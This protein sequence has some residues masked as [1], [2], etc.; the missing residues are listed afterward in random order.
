MSDVD[1]ERLDMLAFDEDDIPLEA[2]SEQEGGG[3]G[4][5]KAFEDMTEQMEMSAPI[6]AQTKL[7]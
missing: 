4:A 6:N 5:G 7:L 2:S 1:T 3:S